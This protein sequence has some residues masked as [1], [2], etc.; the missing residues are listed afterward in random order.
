M[1]FLIREALD[2]MDTRVERGQWH[3][4]IDGIDAHR[5]HSPLVDWVY[6]SVWIADVLDVVDAGV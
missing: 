3:V 2:F 1:G 5:Y 6:D 4:V